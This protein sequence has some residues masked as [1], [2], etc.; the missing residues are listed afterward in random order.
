MTDEEAMVLGRRLKALLPALPVPGSCLL[1]PDGQGRWRVRE[2]GEDDL[3]CYR[4]FGEM[5]LAEW[6]YG[7]P[8]VGD[9]SALIPDLRDRATAGL[10]PSMVREALGAPFAICFEALGF[11]CV[12]SDAFALVDWM[13]GR[14][15]VQLGRG[16]SREEAWIDAWERP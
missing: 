16:T 12:V 14:R 8:S 4:Y 2:G 7:T 5:V 9:F 6:D 11:W 15:D 3:I 13:G 10:L 1:R